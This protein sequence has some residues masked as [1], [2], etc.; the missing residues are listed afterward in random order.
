MPLPLL[1]FPATLREVREEQ[2]LSRPKLAELAGCSCIAIEKIELCGALP[3]LPTYY[4]LC[5]ALKISP[6]DLL[7]RG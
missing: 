1:N 6:G 7:R 3:S 4:R 2:G 5:E